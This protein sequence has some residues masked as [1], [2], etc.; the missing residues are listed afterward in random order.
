M[1][2]FCEDSVPPLVGG[3]SQSLLFSDLSGPAFIFCGASF[4]YHFFMNV[5]GTLRGTRILLSA[6]LVCAGSASPVPAQKVARQWT[7][8][9]SEH[10]VVQG[11][12]R[13]RTAVRLA[14]DLEVLHELLEARLLPAS[15]LEPT[16]VLL[17]KDPKRFQRYSPW[18]GSRGV[19]A[20]FS[21][22]R[23]RR[24]IGVDASLRLS[25]EPSVFHEYL[26]AFADQHFRGMPLWFQEGLAELYSNLSIGERELHVG[27]PIR[28]HLTLLREHWLPLE[29]VL[30]AQPGGAIYSDPRGGGVF[31][32]QA[33]LLVHYL[34]H[35][36][37]SRERLPKLLSLLASGAPASEA[38][39]RT[40]GMTLP[41]LE[42]QLRAYGRRGTLEFLR[43]PR[44][45]V[46]SSIEVA[47]LTPAEIHARLGDLL[48]ERPEPRLSLARRHFERALSLD[49]SQRMALRGLQRLDD[50]LP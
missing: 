17:F 5:R 39:S 3:A 45:E 6:A 16:I 19:S 28:Q 44:P 40:F 12:V 24:Y 31:Y 10:V 23:Q 22:G 25:L 35:H 32:A 18:P 47:T 26:H 11:P 33:W 29:D 49:P 20:Y 43:V 27:L 41:Q 30:E 37:E 14:R 13:E 34:A 42:R 50:R 38:V 36:G 8:V 15:P 48:S 7:E 46:E 4:V 9:R 2:G 1:L 21:R